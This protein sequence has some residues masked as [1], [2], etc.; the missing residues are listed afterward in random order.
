MLLN[1]LLIPKYQLIKTEGCESKT[2]MAGD[3]I[4]TLE[5]AFNTKVQSEKRRDIIEKEV[6]YSIVD[7][8]GKIIKSY[9]TVYD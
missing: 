5:I 6:I 1:G 3:D 8:D 4:I 2:L 7:S 9:N